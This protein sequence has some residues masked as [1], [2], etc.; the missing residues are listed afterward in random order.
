MILIG[1]L[2]FLPGLQNIRWLKSLIVIVFLWTFTLISGASA[3]VLRSAVMFTIIVIGK[4]LKWEGGINN[5]L[6]ASAFLLLC[7]DPYLLWDV[8][9][10]LSYLAIIGILWLQKPIENLLTIK[11]RVYKKIWEMSAITLAAQIIT[12][13]VCLYY[14]HQFP[15]YFLFCNLVAVPL[16]T[17]ILFAEIALLLFSAVP[18]IAYGIAA[19]AAWMIKLLND[20]IIVFSKLPYS[21]TENIYAD[22]Y[23]TAFLYLALLFLLTGLI[24]NRKF[25][26]LSGCVLLTFF[27]ARITLVK[28]R[29][30]KQQK[31][32]VLNLRGSSMIAYI[33]GNQLYYFGDSSAY[34]SSST[35]R[36]YLMPFRQKWLLYKK[37]ILFFNKLNNKFL[38][39]TGKA[40]IMIAD[41]NFRKLTEPLKPFPDLLLITHGKSMKMMDFENISQN[42][43]L[44][45][46]A[47][48]PLWKIRQWKK[49][50]EALNLRRISIPDQGAWAIDLP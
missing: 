28:L 25:A 47:S 19:C 50:C 21:L 2:D 7:Y 14:F 17:C 15:N 1:I 26:F 9:F 12:T 43:M 36:M 49:E 39:K 42:A 37:P 29:S 22:V 35:N 11:N 5:S 38:L 45:F 20:I 18:V 23:S 24:L 8:G 34:Y 41:S 30:I 13:P 4:Q 44:I 31:L 33:Q 6:A 10:Q 27:S 46:D 32:F 16:S 48:N 40:T 3:S